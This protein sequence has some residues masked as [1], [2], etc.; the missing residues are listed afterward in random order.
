MSAA[1]WDGALRYETSWVPV[2]PGV[3]PGPWGLLDHGDWNEAYCSTNRSTPCSFLAR[4]MKSFIMS[5]A[6]KTG[7][8]IR[9]IAVMDEVLVAVIKGF[10]H[11]VRSSQSNLTVGWTVEATAEDADRE[12]MRYGVDD[13]WHSLAMHEPTFPVPP[14]MRMVPFGEDIVG[15]GRRLVVDPVLFRIS[16]F[17]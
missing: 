10:D 17:V 9:Y 5:L 16:M 14:V 3:E 6:S 12:A 8:D 15:V 2:S 11:V 7:G 1:A 13:V 4:S